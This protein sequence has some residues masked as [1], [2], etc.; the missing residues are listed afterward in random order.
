[1]VICPEKMLTWFVVLPLVM[2]TVDGVAPVFV[3]N[4]PAPFMSVR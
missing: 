3:S 2:V 1:L 4:P